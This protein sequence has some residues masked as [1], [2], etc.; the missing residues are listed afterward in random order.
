MN[1]GQTSPNRKSPHRSGLPKAAPPYK[2]LGLCAV[3]IAATAV[4]FVGCDDDDSEPAVD[5]APDIVVTADFQCTLGANYLPVTTR[6]EIQTAELITTFVT[7]EG[8][9]P[10]Q[11]NTLMTDGTPI[12]LFVADANGEQV[13]A[14]GSFVSSPSPIEAVSDGL[15]LVTG[16]TTD[17]FYCIQEGVFW[18]FASTDEYAGLTEPLRSRRGFPVRCVSRAEWRCQC[19]DDC[20]EVDVDAGPD[21]ALDMGVI[22][23]DAGDMMPDAELPT[24]TLNYDSPAADELE[25]G[26]RG[27]FREGR[28]DNVILTFKVAEGGAVPTSPVTVD[29]TLAPDSPSDIQLQPATVVADADGFARVRVTAGVTPGVTA[30]VATATQGAQSETRTSPTISIRGGI[31]SHRGFTF[32]CNQSVIPSFL[33]RAPATWPMSLIPEAAECTVLLSDRLGGVIDEPTQVFYLSEAGNVEQAVP[34]DNQGL[35]V[36]KFGASE[37]PPDDFLNPGIFDPQDGLATLVAITRGEEEFTD[38]NANGVYDP[39]EPLVDLPEPFVDSNDNGVHDFGELYRDTNG[40]GMWNPAN[41]QWDNNIEIWRSTKILLTGD[42]SPVTSRVD[43]DC[44]NGLCSNRAEFDASCPPGLD[45]YLNDLGRLDF[46]MYPLDD[47]SNCVLGSVDV[48]S[49]LNDLRIAP[50]I[51]ES[52]DITPDDCFQNGQPGGSAFNFSLID[53]S[54]REPGDEIEVGEVNITLTYRRSTGEQVTENYIYSVCLP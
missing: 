14:A 29:F 15:T 41:M 20:S 39:G 11:P 52:F 12:D 30:V 33:R 10:A 21:A 26:I 47:N 1:T 36:T 46:T 9:D 37:P 4:G 17:E 5:P 42:L 27:S 25:I 3:M 38:N 8:R 6:E 43:I 28:G 31:P 32:V 48:E 24:L 2:L 45:Y 49:D 13:T 19:E 44:A 35:S 22:D 50:G 23:S 40:D 53:G 54:Q 16:R 34:T 7:V 18:L 51:M